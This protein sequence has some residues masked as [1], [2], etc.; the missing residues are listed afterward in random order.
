MV[1]TDLPQDVL[2]ERLWLLCLGVE[3]EAGCTM[4]APYPSDNIYNSFTGD[5]HAAYGRT[6]GNTDFIGSKTYANKTIGGDGGRAKYL[7]NLL[8]EAAKGGT[9]T[10]PV[11]KNAQGFGCGGG[12]GYGLSD[13]GNGSGGYARISWNMYWDIALNSGK[14]DYKYTD[15]GSGGG[16]ASGNTITET[17]RVNEGQ[18]IKK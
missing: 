15:L 7:G 3:I 12:G 17:V 11:G 4:V 13:G 5:G 9:A 1:V 2:A 14:G 18:V 8:A 6:A 16:G 10:Y